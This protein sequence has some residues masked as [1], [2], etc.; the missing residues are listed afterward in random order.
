MPSG[1]GLV[2]ALVGEGN[3][4]FRAL[5]LGGALRDAVGEGG[6]TTL[7]ELGG[8]DTFEQRWHV[9]RVGARQ[10]Q[11]ELVATDA[12]RVVSVAKDPTEPLTERSDRSVARLVAVFVIDQLEIVE[13]DEHQREGPAIPHAPRDRHVEEAIEG[14]TVEES[15]ERIVPGVVSQDFHPQRDHAEAGHEGCINT[16]CV[17]C[18][19]RIEAGWRIQEGFAAGVVEW[20]AAGSEHLTPEARLVDDHRGVV[21]LVLGDQ[22]IEGVVDDREPTLARREFP[23]HLGPEIAHRFAAWNRGEEVPG[24]VRLRLG[25]Q[26]RSQ[27]APESTLSCHDSSPR[28]PSDFTLRRPSDCACQT[29][30]SRDRQVVQIIGHARRSHDR[31]CREDTDR[32][33]P[34]FWH[35]IDR[36]GVRCC[37]TRSPTL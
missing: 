25:G 17:E 2:E 12:R 27:T 32:D 7:G 14:A 3:E 20:F 31:N 21:Q 19:V 30:L 33:R 37:F 35:R 10:D 26:Q 34:R 4:G 11:R 28:R 16:V 6:A 22:R 18:R 29:L 1:F 8:A 36:G 23:D 13:I 9:V 24:R 15:G 5:S